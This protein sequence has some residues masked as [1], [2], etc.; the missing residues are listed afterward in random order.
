MPDEAI[1]KQ[2]FAA[3]CNAMKFRK[4]PH[5][6]GIVVLT[7]WEPGA[8]GRRSNLAHSILGIQPGD[9]VDYRSR[10]SLQDSLPVGAPTPRT[11]VL[12]SLSR[13]LARMEARLFSK[14]YFEHSCF[15][16]I[17]KNRPILPFRLEQSVLPH[18]GMGSE[19]IEIQ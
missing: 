16:G 5:D 2:A 15:H 9:T 1:R 12:S 14:F 11:S 18:F 4:E 8:G 19:I 3:I 17:R 7:L 6:G 10:T 13:A